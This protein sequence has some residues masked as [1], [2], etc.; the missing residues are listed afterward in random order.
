MTRCRT[1]F[2]EHQNP[3]VFA[4]VFTLHGSMILDVSVPNLLRW[5]CPVNREA[6][7]NRFGSMFPHSRISSSRNR[8]SNS[9]SI[10][11]L[12]AM[13]WGGASCLAARQLQ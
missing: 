12:I 11:W 9:I 6:I 13:D 5:R 8:F 10:F 4:A 1:V 3:Y 2:V 7:C